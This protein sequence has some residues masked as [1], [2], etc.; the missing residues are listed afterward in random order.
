MPRARSFQFLTN[1]AVVMAV[2]LV[3]EVLIFSLMSE[4][5]FTADNIRNVLVQSVFILLLAVGMTFVLITGGIDLSVGAVLGFSAGMSVFVLLITESF[6]LSILAGLGAGVLVGLVNGLMVAKLGIND[7][8]VTLGTLG[9]AAGALRLLDADRPLRE[10]DSPAFDA[11]ANERVI[12][13]PVPVIIGAGVVLFL[14]FVLRRTAFGRAVF[15]TGISRKAAGLA[16]VRVDRVRIGV[17]VLSGFVAAIAGLL[18]AS[19]LGSVPA[20]LGS[21]F[22]L[23]AIAAAVLGGTAL[24]GGRGSVLGT[25]VGALILG[26]LDNG[27]QLIG[28]DVAWF[29][30]IAGASI[31]AAMAL[32]ERIRNIVLSRLRSIGDASSAGGD[33]A[34]GYREAFKP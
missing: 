3:I 7:F 20:R 12:G 23:E 9:V 8:I 26:T 21:G 11:M 18:L 32:D 27:L 1:T 6:A 2:L 25:V 31:V 4:N 28:V 19:R 22:E 10:F 14:E 34:A 17:F 15:A 33:T 30:V 13:I 16:G 24:A 29:R 5:F